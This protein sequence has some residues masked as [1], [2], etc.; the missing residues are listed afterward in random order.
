MALFQMVLRSI[1][2]ISVVLYLYYF[3][4]RKKHNVVIYMWMII[5][6][7]MTSGLLIQIIGVYLRT[8]QWASIQISIYFYLALI[9]YSIWKLITELKKRGH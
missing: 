8:S 2:V 4:K 5:I 3:S 9:I 6:V 1:F 7:G